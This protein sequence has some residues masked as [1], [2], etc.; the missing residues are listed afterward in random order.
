MSDRLLVITQKNPLKEKTYKLVTSSGFDHFIMVTIMANCIVMSMS[1]YGEPPWYT[2]MTS[3]LNYIF[4]A[5]FTVE[6]LLKIYA[7][8]FPGYWLEPWNRFDFVIV[9][10]CL[11]DIVI[12]DILQAKSFSSSVF[13][14]FRIGR[15]LGRVA[16]M[17]RVIKEVQSLNQIFQTLI[18]SMPALFYMGILV[19]VRFPTVF[20][21]CFD[22]FETDLGLF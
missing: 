20:R 1:Y 3:I 6:M 14:L 9:M 5:I 2:T 11:L 8:S 13:R 10:G 7:L 4:T 12:S 15:V 18:E 19:V 22:C 17:F 16:R 21:Q